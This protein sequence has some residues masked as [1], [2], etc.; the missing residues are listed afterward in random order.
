MN[1][2]TN[3]FA[4][5]KQ[6]TAVLKGI[7]IIAMLLHHLYGC[8]PE[9]Y[10][11]FDG[12]LS[13]LG[14]LGKVCVAM[15]LFCSGY[16]LSFGYEKITGLKDTLRFI[17]KRF[18]KFYAG[19]WPI[20]LIFVPI[21]VFVFDRSLSVPYGEDSNVFKCLILDF[22][23][24]QGFSSYNI[25]W[26]F[27]KLIICLY[28]LF[29]ILYTWARKNWWSILL[30]SILA[31]R[32]CYRFKGCFLEDVC[33]YSC[34]FVL[35]ILWRQHQ[36]K[37]YTISQWSISHRWGMLSVAM[38][39]LLIVL[40]LRMN[41]VIPH[42]TGIRLDGFLA[43]A[44]VLCY[45]SMQVF[46][47]SWKTNPFVFLGRHSMNIYMTHTFIFSYWF[48]REIYSCEAVLG[49]AFFVLLIASLTISI[50][51]EWMKEISRYNKLL[52]FVIEKI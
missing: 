33:L 42:W 38:S 41:P 23:G 25:T 15:F 37:M 24:V 13:F 35:G 36:E 1:N 16:G 49:G 32:L 27:N 19:Y 20:F 14:N 48:A 26:W 2:Q 9:A 43:C 40:V 44:I 4:L 46:C 3:I 51:I 47:S 45:K 21:G 6:D 50:L 17:A 28:L 31:M 5:T 29:P 10:Q 30:F 34:P 18:V 8:A 22:L 7:A 12:F 52:K 11:P 39:L